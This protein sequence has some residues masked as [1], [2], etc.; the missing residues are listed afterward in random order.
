MSPH[1]CHSY[2]EGEYVSMVEGR[3]GVRGEEGG[4]REGERWEGGGY[5][6]IKEGRAQ[7]FHEVKFSYM[8]MRTESCWW[9]QMKGM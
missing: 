2:R 6:K 7:N 3:G 5:E 9:I 8:C 4:G 1:N